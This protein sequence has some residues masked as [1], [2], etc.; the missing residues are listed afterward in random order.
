MK[1]STPVPQEAV[2]KGELIVGGMLQDAAHYQLL[3]LAVDS[4]DDV[5][6]VKSVAVLGRVAIF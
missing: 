4:E 3:F 2:G 1:T 5:Y 6:I